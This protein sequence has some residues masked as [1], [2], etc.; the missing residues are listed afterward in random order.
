MKNLVIDAVWTAAGTTWQLFREGALNGVI[1]AGGLL[2]AVKNLKS[3]EKKVSLRHEVAYVNETVFQSLYEN[4]VERVLS[5]PN[6]LSVLLG[7]LVVLALTLV[8]LALTTTV[9]VFVNV[10]NH[11][12]VR[13]LGNA[14]R[15]VV[16]SVATA[17]TNHWLRVLLFLTRATAVAAVVVV[18]AAAAVAV[19]PPAQRAFAIITTLA[20][21][22]CFIPAVRHGIVTITTQMRRVGD[23]VATTMT[24]HWRSVVLALAVVAAVVATAAHRRRGFIIITVISAALVVVVTVTIVRLRTP[25]PPTTIPAPPPSP[26]SPSASS[27]SP[28]A[29]AGALP[30]KPHEE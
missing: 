11:P 1:I 17:I 24:N 12:T 3:N 10:L 23:D 29:S 2:R 7:S 14:L 30:S 6:V 19:A 20:V 13:A 26:S 22:L 27:L 9:L 28:R 25:I 8:I 4:V 16:I 21:L 5:T 18:V 15:G